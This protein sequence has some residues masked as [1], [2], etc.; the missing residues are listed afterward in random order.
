MD[1]IFVMSLI[2]LSSNVKSAGSPC[3]PTMDIGLAT[4][5]DWC[6]DYKL[7]WHGVRERLEG[8]GALF[9]RYLAAH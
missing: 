6:C 3:T 5:I 1:A 2:S 7:S 4:T 8:G 9:A